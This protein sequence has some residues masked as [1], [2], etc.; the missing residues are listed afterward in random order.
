MPSE[1]VVVV[2]PEHPL[3]S[4]LVAL[5]CAKRRV[6]C[7]DPVERRQKQR[8]VQNGEY[9][10]HPEPDVPPVAESCPELDWAHSVQHPDEEVRNPD[11]RESDAE[12]QP[13]LLRVD[14]DPVVGAIAGREQVLQAPDL[15]ECEHIQPVCG[16][17]L[18]HHDSPFLRYGY[19]R[20]AA[21]RSYFIITQV[22]Q[23]VN[24]NTPTNRGE[25]ANMWSIVCPP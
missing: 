25:I 19:V 13:T 7:I 23:K 4:L 5:V 20:A 1:T 11:Q 9:L 10:P 12:G 2:G 18:V 8:A 3:F 21:L 6:E 16:A 14:A 22:L 24:K 17:C 15:D